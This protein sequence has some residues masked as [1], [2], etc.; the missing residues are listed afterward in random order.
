MECDGAPLSWLYGPL[1]TKPLDR[2]VDHSRRLSGSNY[3][4]GI[5][6]VKS[7]N[8]REAYVYAM[9][10]EPWLRYIM[11][12]EYAPDSDPMIRYALRRRH[13]DRQS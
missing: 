1:I 8:C 9:G 13:A 7:F 3:E 2:K 4:R 5:E 11:A 12:K 10:M 6:I